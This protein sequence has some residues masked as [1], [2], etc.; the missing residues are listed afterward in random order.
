VKNHFHNLKTVLKIFPIIKEAELIE[1]I[2]ETFIKNDQNT[3]K[4]TKKNEQNFTEINDV[5]IQNDKNSEQ[6]D[7]EIVS[8]EG[9]YV[10]MPG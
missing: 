9:Q 7:E 10:K 1:K 4:T 6:K 8:D 2:E 3:K 5:V